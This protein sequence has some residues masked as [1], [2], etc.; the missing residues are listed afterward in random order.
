MS[1][2]GKQ[3]WQIERVGKD[4]IEDWSAATTGVFLTPSAGQ[5]ESFMGL[6]YTRGLTDD[7]AKWLS[8]QHATSL[9]AGN[10]YYLR[11][12][13]HS[14]PGSPTIATAKWAHVPAKSASDFEAEEAKAAKS[15]KEDSTRPSSVRHDRLEKFRI[16]QRDGKWT[17]L[18]GRSHF[19]LHVLAVKPEYQRRGLGALLLSWGLQKAD[20]LGLE[21]YLE[22]S[23]AG[24]KLY[25]TH[26]FEVRGLLDWDATRFEGVKY[27]FTNYA[28]VRPA[29][30]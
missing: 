21:S 4:T 15:R 27:P 22:A 8:S 18:A 29:Q 7:V 5:D 20:A 14:V 2:Q 10:S 19:Y 12:R 1:S 11:I 9:E 23:S 6:F 30:K 13:D 16:A 17:H 25:E 28:M 26:G 24:K 3:D